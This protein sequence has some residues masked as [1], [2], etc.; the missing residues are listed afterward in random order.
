MAKVRVY[1]LARE[2]NMTN[3][4]LL[5]KLGE[6]GFSVT[7]HVSTLDEA[8]VAKV[9][10]GILGKKTEEVEL[11]RIKPTVIR[12][13]VRRVREA[14]PAE[15]V[16]APPETEAPAPPEIQAPTPPAETGPP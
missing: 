16:A 10:S 6:L 4:M 11:T 8:Q 3:K 9:K 12:R 7:S 13:R 1:E 5:E 2:L 14:P 15:E